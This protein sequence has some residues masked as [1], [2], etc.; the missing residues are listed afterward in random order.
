MITMAVKLV[1]SESLA[2]ASAAVHFLSD[3]GRASPSKA[4]SLLNKGQDS[5]LKLIKS[6]MAKGDEVRYRV[7][8][9]VVYNFL[10][11]VWIGFFFIYF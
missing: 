7:F 6:V 4:F 9:V 3:Y 11:T 1:G 5:H 8:E 10:L 2:V